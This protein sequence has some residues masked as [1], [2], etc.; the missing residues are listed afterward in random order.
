[1][2][3]IADQIRHLS[4]QWLESGDEDIPQELKALLE[5]RPNVSVL[6]DRLLERYKDGTLSEA[7]DVCWTA[8][9][10]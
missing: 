10:Y 2:G 5:Y 4:K 6:S 8:D 7:G 3:A 1:M 9:N